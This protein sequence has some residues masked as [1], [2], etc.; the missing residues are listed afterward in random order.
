MP[1]AT[2][3]SALPNFISIEEHQSLTA[4]TPE[5]L[6]AIPPVLRHKQED[7]QVTLEPALEGFS[8]DDAKGTLYVIERCVKY[9]LVG[10]SY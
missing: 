7:V 6:S 1:A 3:I 9:G 2:L 10:A 5:D 4:S 8:S